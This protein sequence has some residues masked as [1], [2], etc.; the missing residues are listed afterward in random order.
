MKRIFLFLVATLSIASAQ[1]TKLGSVQTF[2]S[3]IGGSGFSLSSGA[4]YF[5][6]LN[7]SAVQQND[8]S[9]VT[10]TIMT[11]SGVFTNLIA[12]K[13]STSGGEAVVAIRVNARSVVGYTLS[14]SVVTPLIIYRG[15]RSI[16]VSAGDTVHVFFKGLNAA[17]GG[18]QYSVDFL[19]AP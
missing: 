14:D 17:Q 18:V 6:P 13:T 11:R 3:T 8:S 12:R 4:R 9:A 16:S 19:T 10:G 5:S 2:T 7:G 1:I 15:T